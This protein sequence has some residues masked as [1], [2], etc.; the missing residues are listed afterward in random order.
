MAVYSVYVR[1]ILH[2][3][4]MPMLFFL[5]SV[6]VSIPGLCKFIGFKK[7]VYHQKN[8]AWIFLSTLEKFVYIMSLCLSTT[9]GYD[10]ILLQDRLLW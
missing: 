9:F 5:S 8:S 4:C 7:K 3:S 1:N 10:E 6:I 2:N